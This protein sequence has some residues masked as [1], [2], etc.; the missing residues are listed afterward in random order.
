[1]SQIL[2]V[3]DDSD[4]RSILTDA[5]RQEGYDV[6][7]ACNG[8]QALAAFRRHRPDAMVLDLVMPA[9]DGQTL[10]STLRNQTKW[11]A[12]PLVIISGQPDPIAVRRLGARACFEKPLDLSGLLECVQ[13]IA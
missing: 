2:V 10:V 1:M 11:G 6:E 5:L 7:S 13:A 4:V 12:V 9:M 8:V 3:D